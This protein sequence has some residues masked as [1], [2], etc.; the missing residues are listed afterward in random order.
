MWGLSGRLID[1]QS[2]KKKR[3]TIPF[4]FGLAHEENMQHVEGPSSENNGQNWLYIGLARKSFSSAGSFN[5]NGK[6]T[7]AAT[8]L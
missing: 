4:K 7:A 5:H 6:E 8:G 1:P 3:E 2:S